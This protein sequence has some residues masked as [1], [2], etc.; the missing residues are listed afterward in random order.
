MA[1]PPPAAPP[2]PV[3]P[4]PALGVSEGTA[5]LAAAL[6]VV[7]ALLAIAALPVAVVAIPN[8]ISSVAHLL[9]P[10]ADAEAYMRAHGLGLPATVLAASAGALLV[11]RVRPASPLVGGLLL[12]AAAEVLAGWAAAPGA[13][14]FVRVLGGAGAGLLLPATLAA[15]CERPVLARRVLLAVWAA[16]LTTSLAAAQPLALLSVENATSW[17]A[18][19]QPY[20][21]LTGLALTLAAAYLVLRP[22]VAGPGGGSGG[23]SGGGFGGGAAEPGGG[24]REAARTVAPAAVVSALALGTSTGW[25]APLQIGAAA[26]AVL[27]LLVVAVAEG[28]MGGVSAVAA[29]LVVLPS[30]AQIAS[31]TLEP[32]GGPGLDAL[33]LPL[34]VSALGA[35]GAGVA[36]A[37]LERPAPGRVAAAALVTVVAGLCAVR[38]L[39]PGEGVAPYALT[40]TLLTAGG[41][42]ALAAALRPLPE[43]AALSALACC[44][45]GVLAGFLL[46]GGVQRAVLARGLTE[47]EDLARALTSA[48]HLWCL[49]AGF[50]VVAALAAAAVRARRRARSRG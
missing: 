43:R 23:G 27:G 44:L 42:G 13:V 19:L 8:T 3:P 41:A 7:I 29:G 10:G 33:W 28:R 38:L 15:V 50:A 1:V 22:R 25:A 20:P 18:S 31:L 24:W 14:A 30:V 26:V 4:R 45:P 37:G 2:G 36:A 9:P 47:P 40:F 16:A 6:D 48:L 35:M 12:V 5:R 46:G 49:I 39:V 32:L 34:A 17:R 11:R 21:L